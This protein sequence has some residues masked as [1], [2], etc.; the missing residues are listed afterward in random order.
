MDRLYTKEHII[1]YFNKSYK[2]QLCGDLQLRFEDGDRR[3][4]GGVAKSK[5]G[6]RILDIKV[7]NTSFCPQ[8]KVMLLG[9]MYNEAS[10]QYYLY[11]TLEQDMQ[12]SYLESWRDAD[13]SEMLTIQDTTAKNELHASILA[14]KINNI[15]KELSFIDQVAQNE[16]IKEG[17]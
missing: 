2:A 13:I 6:I 1:D 9:R 16:Q 15:Q 12:R 7:S 8:S 5:E 11:N 10:W 4:Y 3:V 17:L 14:D